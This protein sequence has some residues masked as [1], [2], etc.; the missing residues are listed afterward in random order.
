MEI[1]QAFD[2]A[3]KKI[4]PAI[5]I[6]EPLSQHTTI[7]IGGPARRFVT[8][9]DAGQLA[10]AVKL[11]RRYQ[12]PC[13]ILGGGSN[14]IISDAGFPGVVI[15]NRSQSWNLVS[16]QST[17]K[18]VSKTSPRLAP[19]GDKYYQADDLEYS[20]ADDPPVLVQVDSGAKIDPLIKTLLQNG[21]TGLQWFSGIPATVGGAVYMNMHG[22]YRFF[23][24]LLVKAA[25]IDGGEIKEVDRDYFQFD[26]D[27]SILHETKETVLWAQLL[28]R[29]GHVERA[30]ATAREWARRKSLQPQKS[31]GCIFRNLTAAEQQ[32]LK[33]PTPSIG[34]VVDHLLKL[35]GVRR[36][37][38]I[39]SPRHAAFVENLGNARAADA[40]AL[41][42]LIRDKAKAELDVDLRTEVEFIGEF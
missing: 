5:K 13:L 12:M 25:L 9:N 10:H 41:I 28:L 26:Y 29:R 38:A 23:G 6:D 1:S 4:F 14:L 27:W 3:L 8:A 42:D 7:G 34:Y 20:E 40:K 22:G 16:D 33:V 39:I 11:C 15:K 37:E 31:A 30:R 24:D 35:K 19:V 36:G 17:E 32:K 18:N 21:V 2:E